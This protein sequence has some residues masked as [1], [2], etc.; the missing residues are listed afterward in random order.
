MGWEG[1]GNP[2]RLLIDDKRILFQSL[3]GLTERLLFL[4]KFPVDQR[5]FALSLLPPDQEAAWRL[6]EE[7][8]NSTIITSNHF[9]FE[10]LDTPLMLH[11]YPDDPG[12]SYAHEQSI[13]PRQNSTKQPFLTADNRFYKKVD[14]WVKNQIRLE[15]QVTKTMYTIKAIVHSCNTVGQYQ[16]VSPELVT[17]LPDKYKQ[18][19]KDYTKKSP[20]PAITVEPSDID[21]AIANLAFAS[22]QPETSAEEAYKRYLS[23]RST[24]RLPQ[25]ARTKRYE[26]T[27]SRRLNM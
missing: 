13:F 24:Y 11:K 8:F 3:L 21:A 27:S 5:D 15:E 16:R 23:G 4:N 2:A 10:H 17:F 14:K 6:L 18:A 12:S 26:S 25:F 20:Y 7:E 1:I 22:L 19:L 9:Y